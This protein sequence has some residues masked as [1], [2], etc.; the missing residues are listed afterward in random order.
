MT[1]LE[2]AAVS[3]ILCTPDTTYGEVAGHMFVMQ[4]ISSEDEYLLFQKLI[5]KGHHVIKLPRL[6]MLSLSISS[7]DYVI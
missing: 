7:N 2:E 5:Q 4:G 1:A 6:G 3:H